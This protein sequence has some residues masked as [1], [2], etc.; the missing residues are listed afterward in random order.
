ME[1]ADVKKEALSFDVSVNDVKKVRLSS[2]ERSRPFAAKKRGKNADVKNGVFSLVIC[3]K[4]RSPRRFSGKER[5]SG[6]R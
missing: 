6:K 1:A 4:R 5:E 3:K 2:E